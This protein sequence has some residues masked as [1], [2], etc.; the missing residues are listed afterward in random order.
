M[1]MK[2]G[3]KMFSTNKFATELEK[4]MLETDHIQGRRIYIPDTGEILNYKNILRII[5][6]GEKNDPVEQ[7]KIQIDVNEERYAGLFFSAVYNTVC[8]VNQMNNM[9]S[10]Y[11]FT[12]MINLINQVNASE[13]EYIGSCFSLSRMRDGD[14]GITIIRPIAPKDIQRLNANTKSDT[15]QIITKEKFIESIKSKLKL[16]KITVPKVASLPRRDGQTVDSWLFDMGPMLTVIPETDGS[17]KEVTVGMKINVSKKDIEIYT[18]ITYSIANILLGWDYERWRAA[19]REIQSEQK[20]FQVND[21]A[22]YGGITNGIETLI[23]ERRINKFAGN[24]SN[25][26]LIN[27]EKYK[28]SL[29]DILRQNHFIPSEILVKF[30]DKNRNAYTYK[31]PGGLMVLVIPDENNYMRQVGVGIPTP[32]DESQYDL[33]MG[34][35]FCAINAIHRYSNEKFT[36]FV[37]EINKHRTPVYQTYFFPL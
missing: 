36:A 1:G 18:D 17:I 14:T 6:S 32:T 37:Q 33:Y 3:S 11:S 23:F 20:R 35:C 31:F 26:I 2:V 15:A 34:L 27:Q 16:L 19:F 25:R 8:L 9:E 22:V 7:I 28:D 29:E 4:K 13:N 24:S 30:V 21:Y 10:Q 12:E 5:I